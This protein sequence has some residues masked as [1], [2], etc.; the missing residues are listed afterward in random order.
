[1][2]GEMKNIEMGFVERQKELGDAL[3]R[4]EEKAKESEREN[5]RLK[6][7]I[8]RLVELDDVKNRQI[9]D[10][11]KRLEILA[12]EVRDRTEQQICGDDVLP[13]ELWRLFER[14][15]CAGRFRGWWNFGR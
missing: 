6:R 2:T 11:E 10:M 1:M 3:E 13:W 4:A 5:A 9:C 14:M 8:L 12:L 7:Q 15:V